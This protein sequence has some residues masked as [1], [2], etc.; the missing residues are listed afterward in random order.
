VNLD[1]SGFNK[2]LFL[3]G[4]LPALVALVTIVTSLVLWLALEAKQD[5]SI[6]K[7]TKANA[8][9][10]QNQINAR[11]ESRIRALMRM[12]KR[13]EFSG[14]PVR[15]AWEDDVANYLHDYQD[16]QAIE[17][18]DSSHLV[19]W[20]VP[21]KGNETKLG[22]N[23]LLEQRRGRAAEMAQQE[24]EP[25]VTQPVELFHGGTGF[26]IYA[27]IYIGTNF[28]G[29]LG[30]VFNAQKVFDTCLP[31]RIATGNSIAISESG[32]KIYQRNPS[33]LPAGQ[34]WIVDS[35]IE[36]NG[37]VWNVRVWPTPELIAQLDTSLPKII[38][39]VGLV[40]SLLLSVAVRL[41]QVA[42]IQVGKIAEQTTELK[43]F[44]Q[45]LREALEKV[46]TLS[47][48]L[49]ICGRCKK[50]RDDGGYWSQI[51]T[52]VT[53]HS[54]AS[55]SHGLCP[56]CSIKFFEDGGLPMPDKVREAAKKMK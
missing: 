43:R 16:L 48:L 40:M 11:M 27:P 33:P 39:L 56:E 45:E 26:V 6:A 34:D 55:F 7:T 18:I 31:D 3:K 5:F 50:V 22:V 25:V 36:L 21:L 44:N 29:V 41:T 54:D 15:A 14:R 24:R 19:R 32:V 46:K 10:V 23:L 42:R 17:W 51:E 12:A 37:T 30:G 2:K 47:G 4:W 53:R 49:P 1:E 13:W 9:N 35:K 38:L 52:Y 28:D 8:E 20:I